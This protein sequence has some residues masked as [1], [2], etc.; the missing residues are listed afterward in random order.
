MGHRKNLLV[1][2]FETP[3]KLKLWIV[4][5]RYV[6]HRHQRARKHEAY[7]YNDVKSRQEVHLSISYQ[8]KV[9]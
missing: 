9:R 2:A 1:F 6:S 3:V 7:A 5:P 4:Y 8:A